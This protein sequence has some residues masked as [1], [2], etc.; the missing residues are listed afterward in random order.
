MLRNKRYHEFWPSKLVV[1]P[2]PVG[3][4]VIVTCLLRERTRQHRAREGGTGSAG[5]L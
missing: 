2:Q 1:P 5:L 3:V 4:Y